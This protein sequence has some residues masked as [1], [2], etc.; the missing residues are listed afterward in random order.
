MR[1]VLAAAF[2]IIGLGACSAKPGPPENQATAN[3]KVTAEANVSGNMA[4]VSVAESNAS[5]KL[6]PAD[7]ALRF[8]GTWAASKGDCASK[9]WRFTA[10]ALSGGGPHCSFYKVTK[11]PGGY[12]IA[13]TCPA[14]EPVHTD[15]I[16]LRFA[17]SAGAMLVESN[18]IS[19][20][21]LIYCGK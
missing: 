6:P 10:D 11:A 12:D 2:V 17:E 18:A 5:A 13:A 19:P 16:R 14:K 15:L 20:T 8:V 3:E 7:A 4:G 21:G 1:G 9:P